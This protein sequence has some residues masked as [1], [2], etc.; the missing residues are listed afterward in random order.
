VLVRFLLFDIVCYC[1]FL[2]NKTLVAHLVHQ[3]SD[4]FS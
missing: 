3:I 2:V 1:H 4:K